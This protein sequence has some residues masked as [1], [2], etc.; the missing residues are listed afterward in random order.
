MGA[1]EDALQVDRDDAAPNARGHLGEEAEVVDA[2]VVDQ[3]LE[4]SAAA[5]TAD[6]AEA[7]SVTSSDV[8]AAPISRGDLP[9]PSTFRSPITTSAPS[10]AS[11]RAIAAPIPLAP[12]VTSA[13]RPSSLIERSICARGCGRRE[14]TPPQPEPIPIIGGTGALGWGLAM[15]LARAGQPVVIGSRSEERADEAARRLP[16]ACPTPRSRD[17]VNE[18]GR[19]ARAD[20]LPDGAVPR[21][22][23]EPEQPARGAGAGADPG[24]LHGPDRRGRRRQ[25]DPLA[26]RLAGLGGRSR[27]R[28][29]SPTGSTVVA[30]LHTVSAPVLADPDAELDEDVLICGDRKADKARVA[31]IVEL[32]PGLRAVNAGALETARIV[33]QLTPMLISI[34]ARY[35]AHAGIRITGLGEAE[36]WESV[37]AAARAER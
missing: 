33:E 1:G 9:A 30:A 11:R 27:R 24:R 5:T 16:S 37:G 34:N 10:A 19:A 28:R 36:P 8:A 20:R 4:R 23:G 21:P 12:P 32:I 13:L 6:A 2:G 29:W 31:R 3:D 18:R 7:G 26:R 17:C 14:Y 25:G 35:K 22:V 15:R